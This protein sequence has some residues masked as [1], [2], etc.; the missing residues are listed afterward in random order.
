MG[1]DEVTE[2]ILATLRRPRG[3]SNLVVT[4]Q[5][6][7]Q[8]RVQIAGIECFGGIRSMEVIKQEN[9]QKCLIPYADVERLEVELVGTQS[10]SY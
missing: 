3:D 7:E 10:S 1:Q 8:L 5:N 9:G 6:G 4:L 2:I